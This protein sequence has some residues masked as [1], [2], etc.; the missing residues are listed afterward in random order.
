MQV[1]DASSGKI[2]YIYHGYNVAVAR[3]DNSK[4]VLPDLIYF[5]AWSHN[6]K[7]IAAVTRE[8]CGDEC[9]VLITWD[10][11]TGKHLV[12]Y[13]DLPVY[14]LAWSPDDTRFASAIGISDVQIALVP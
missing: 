7:R 8:Y 4:G 14:A 5:V 1:W 10:A 11:Q 2:R 3:I 6:G 9:A 12:F 13:P